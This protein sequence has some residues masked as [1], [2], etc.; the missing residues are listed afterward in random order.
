MN[1]NNDAQIV[2][3]RFK[4]ALEGRMTQE[5]AKSCHVDAYIDRMTENMVGRITREVLG[6]TI[7][8]IKYPENWKEAVKEAFFN[9]IDSVKWLSLLKEKHPVKYKVYDAVM[10]YPT[11]VMPEREHVFDFVERRN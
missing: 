4:F 10:Y 1:Y 2:L 8:T 6:H 3:Q 5:M 11:L 9:W 7:D